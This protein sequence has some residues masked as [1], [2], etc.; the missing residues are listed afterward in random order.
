MKNE[1]DIGVRIAAASQDFVE[2][3]KIGDGVEPAGRLFR[4]EASVEIGAYGGVTRTPGDLADVI[5][6]VGDGVEGNRAAGSFADHEAR[7]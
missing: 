1:I 3:L 6:V 5:D 7:F 4:A 2:L